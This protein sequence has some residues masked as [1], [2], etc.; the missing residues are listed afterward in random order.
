MFLSDYD[1]Y[2]IVQDLPIAGKIATNTSVGG[3]I[4]VCIL[5]YI[6]LINMQQNTF[7]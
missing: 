5:M 7:S 4:H 6:E 2:W 3:N 1:F